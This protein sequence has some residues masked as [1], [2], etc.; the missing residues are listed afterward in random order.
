MTVC[1]KGLAHTECCSAQQNSSWVDL[2]VSALPACPAQAPPIT[3]FA[4]DSSFPTTPGS[5]S[6]LTPGQ[7]TT[8][9]FRS[10]PY[11]SILH[12]PMVA[13]SHS[14]SKLGSTSGL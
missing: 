5:L 10:S 13:P 9:N 11:S 7:N 1:V 2:V 3:S 6:E 4:V 14:C 12:R 8:L